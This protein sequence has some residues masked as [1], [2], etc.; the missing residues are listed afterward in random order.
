M[1]QFMKKKRNAEGK[2]KGLFHVSNED[3]KERST[4]K[5]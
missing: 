2:N 4:Q 1:M 3:N 5:K